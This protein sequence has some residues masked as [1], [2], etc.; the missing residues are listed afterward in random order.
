MGWDA[1]VVPSYRRHETLR[2]KTLALLAERHVDPEGIH[3]WVADDDEREVYLETLRPGS[4]GRIRVG[5]PGMGAIRNCIT[6]A[7]PK[8]AKLVMLDD[9]VSDV[10]QRVNAKVTEPV[11]DLRP[12]FAEAFAYAEMVGAS[13]W[14]VYPV[15]NAMFMKAK[16]TTDLRY[17]VGC[18]W[19][20]VNDPEAD[21]QRVTLD[22]KE[23]FERTIRHYLHDGAVVRFSNVA[24]ITR[25]YKEPGGMQVERTPERVEESALYLVRE[26]PDLCSL[27]T[28]KKS[29]HVE[30]RLKD[31]RP[32]EGR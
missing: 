32:Q 14:G 13:L 28:T 25:Y 3:V 18:M 12:F 23:D 5:K 24:P 16:I 11:E 19:G 1:V 29:G 30:V 22:D 17:I 9:D 26:Y 27:N 7:Y 2:D 8:G 15:H 20:K 4:Y 10:K 31:R 6:E 21:Y